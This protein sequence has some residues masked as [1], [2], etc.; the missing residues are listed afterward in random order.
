MTKFILLFSLLALGA[1]GGGSDSG[2]DAQIPGVSLAG[3]MV[4]DRFTG[5]YNGSIQGTASAL[6]VTLSDSFPITITVNQN[7][8]RFDGDDPDETF[9]VGLRNDGTFSGILNYND[10]QCAGDVQVEGI[11]DGNNA[12]GSFGGEGSCEYGGNTIDVELIG[13]FTAAK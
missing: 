2:A 13:T 10:D 9:S 11:V 8:V 3:D 12:S 5:V 1:C 7:M 4:P 6:G